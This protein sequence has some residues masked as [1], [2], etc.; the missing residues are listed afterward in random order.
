MSTAPP[1]TRVRRVRHELKRRELE[2]LRVESLTANFRS[3]TF[4]GDSLGDFVS[5]SF[6]DHLKFILESD[7]AEPVRRDYTPRAF[8]R[9]ARELTIEFA[10]HG[11][12]STPTGGSGDGPVT[13]WAARAEARQ[14]VTIGG[15]RGSM[16]IPVDYDWHLLAGDET[17]L[18]AISRRLEELPV[19]ARVIVIGQVENPADRRAFAAGPSRSVQ[20]VASDAEMI[21]AVRALQLPAGEG[22]AWCAGE[23]ATMVTLRRI[24][25]N[26]KGHPKDAI[27]AAAYWKRGAVAHHENLED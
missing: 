5:E 24:L 8:D 15:P 17:A 11:A 18:P 12:G 19:D 6:D 3:I 4:G 1:I 14:R 7:Q 13:R 20:W 2:V 22:Y 21:E 23:S 9:V 27:R 26:D 16:I 25:V 10:L